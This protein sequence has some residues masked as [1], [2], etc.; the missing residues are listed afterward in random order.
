MKP[1]VVIE[2]SS[3]YG[4]YDC[5][6]KGVVDGYCRGGDGTPCAVVILDKNNRFVMVY[7]HSL[8]F[9]EWL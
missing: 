6:D 9:L 7:I 8:K 4:E 3:P 1:K 5:G 2:G